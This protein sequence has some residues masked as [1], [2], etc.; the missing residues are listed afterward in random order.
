MRPTN[1][2]MSAFGP[3]AGVVDIPMQELGE[4]GLYL[5]T[6]DTGAGKTTIFDA[7][8]FA[9]FGDASG[10]NREASMFRSKYAEASVPTYVELHFEHGNQTYYIKRNPEY[11]RPAK[12]GDGL[13]KEAADAQLYLPD[14]TIV[15]KVKDVN[16]AVEELLGI[17]KEQFSQIVM[18]AQGDFLKLLLADTKQRQEIFRELFGTGM[19]Q[20][21][22]YKLEEERKAAYGVCEDARKSI[23]QYVSGIDCAENSEFVGQV[24]QAKVGQLSTEDILLLLEKI[25]EA[26]NAELERIAKQIATQDECLER[27]NQLIGKATEISNTK[28]ALSD[29]EVELQQKQDM[30]EAIV[31]AF[32][33]SKLAV[34][35]KEKLLQQ[36]ALVEA[37]LPNYKVYD[38]LMLATKQLIAERERLSAQC[39]QQT[40]AIKQKEAFVQTLKQE[41]EELKDVGAARERLLANQ[42]KGFVQIQSYEQL[43]N[44][45]DK[46]DAK[47]KELQH[48]QEQYLEL[49]REYQR[50]RERYEQMDQAFRDGQAGVL[51]AS[52]KAGDACPVCGSTTHPKLACVAA[53]VPS[54]Q[55]LNDAKERAES[56]RKNAEAG[57]KQAG[58]VKT[59][60]ESFAGDIRETIVKLFETDDFEAAQVALKNQMDIALEK[61]QLLQS[62]LAETEKKITRKT[63]LD[64]LLPKEEKLLGEEKEQ[65]QKSQEQLAVYDAKIAEQSK[66]EIS[67]RSSLQFE[68]GDAAMQQCK[69]LG[70]KI[71]ELQEDYDRKEKAYREQEDAVKRLQN[72]VE[73]YRN[74]LKNAKETNLDELEQEKGTVTTLRNQL[75]AVT[76]TLQTRMKGNQ[77][78]ITNVKK[79]YSLVEE[80]E[81]QLQWITVLADTANGK[82]RGKEKIMLETYV[83]MT[84]FERILRRA[85]I[86]LMKMSGAQYELKR[87]KQAANNRGQSGLDL[88]VLDHYNGTERSV[89]TLSG[90]ESFMASLSLALGLSE[91]VQMS[92]GGIQIDTM[93]VDEGFGSLDPDSL[94]LAYQALASLTEGKR[95]VGIISHVAEL[96]DKIDKQICVTKEKSGGSFVSI[97]V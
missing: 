42:E 12:R 50:C 73:T 65:L 56:A 11:M 36:K 24:E 13:K 54:E 44:Q 58:E 77:D 84:Y 29:A 3:Y 89:K 55:A 95:L 75:R 70:Q 85:N 93:F 25:V 43:A 61:H 90:G 38:D 21:L 8:S 41:A 88:A 81:K 10:D 37:E 92:A 72:M 19:Y 96:K 86:R 91:E 26:D 31:T 2:K 47:K 46:L 45:F 33:Q 74:T 7:I 87:M 9:L 67:L 18:V 69:Q 83:Q 6:G 30:T 57:S 5:I 35:E 59:L 66:Q 97:R 4:Q 49:D 78:I 40:E 94:D 20:S 23:A 1:L 64:E 14:G 27:V 62:E 48:V 52:L 68:S 15:S 60:V 22:Q 28:K 16:A 63:Q 71:L 32:E 79:K 53:D 80:Q 51:A 34:K 17:N 76:E 39:L 82:L